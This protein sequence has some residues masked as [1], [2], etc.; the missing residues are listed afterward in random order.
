MS[1]RKAHGNGAKALVRVESAPVDEL[2]ALNATDTTAGRALVAGRGKPFERGNRSAAGRKPALASV[3]GMPTGAKDPRYA[4]ALRWARTF[5][6]QRVRELT[7][8]HGG[9]LSSGV[10]AMLT[11]AALDLAGARYLTA[12]NADRETPVPDSMRLASQLHQSGRQ[13]E[14]TALEI[15][16]R[17]AESN[18]A[19]RGWVDPLAAFYDTDVTDTDPK[20]TK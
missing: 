16:K 15:A 6:R 10:C 20:A 11:S 3:A 9:A 1:L 8:Q 18:R 4:R 14:L 2:G 13:L 5:R 19:L 7:V 12:V 17:E